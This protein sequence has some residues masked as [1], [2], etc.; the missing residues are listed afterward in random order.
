MRKSTY[1]NSTPNTKASI[2]CPEIA[3]Y[4]ID[5]SKHKQQHPDNDMC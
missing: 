4:T 5:D 3:M 1:P 2:P